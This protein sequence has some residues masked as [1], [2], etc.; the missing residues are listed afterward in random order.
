[1]DQPGRPPL[2]HVPQQTPHLTRRDVRGLSQP[3][4]DAVCRDNGSVGELRQLRPPSEFRPGD[5]GSTAAERSVSDHSVVRAHADAPD[6]PGPAPDRSSDPVPS[7][8]AEPD[9]VREELSRFDP[10][11]CGLPEVSKGDAARYVEANRGDRPWLNVVRHA[12]EDVRRVFA[13]IDQGG[14]HAQI[15]HEG[16]LSPEKS[17]L[18]VLGLQDPAQLDPAK[19]SDGIDGLLPGDKPHYC[20]TESSAI[21]DPT[22]FAAGFA[23]GVEHPDVRSAIETPRVP[24][25]QPPRPVVVPIADLLGPDGHRY[26]EGYRLV[27]DDAD[28]ARRDRRTWLRETGAGEL[29]SVPP[30][31]IVPLDFR[32]GD[33]EFRFKVNK[34]GSGYE[35]AT[36]FPAL[37]DS[38]R[39][40]QVTE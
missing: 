14:G 25:Q 24:G 22:A 9:H 28:I 1:M 23:R 34:A 3:G 39:D 38:R 7:P 17:Q 37:R 4:H 27:G 15:R 5:Q 30:P 6:A 2:H 32:G 13:A 18:R 29:P 12:P 19:R 16:W 8:Q 35:I 20:A 31:L 33:I 11:R 21:R 40:D 36:M 10:R 26:C